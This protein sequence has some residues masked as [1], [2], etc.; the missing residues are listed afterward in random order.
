M[1][2]TIYDLLDRFGAEEVSSWMRGD[3]SILGRLEEGDVEEVAGWDFWSRPGQR[4]EP[5]PETITY[6]SAGRGFGKSLV[7]AHALGEA[8]LDPERWGGEALL[9]GITPGDARALC[10][11]DTGIIRVAAEWGYPQPA[12]KW[13]MGRGELFF[14]HPR[15][16]GSGLHVR[17]A[18]SANPASARGPNVGLLLADEWAFFRQT[19]DEMGL[20]TWEAAM[21]ALRIGLAKA[22]IVSSPSRSKSVLE[23]RDLAERPKCK[24]CGERLPRSPRVKISPLFSADTTQP[25]RTCECGATVTAQVRM[26]RAS[27]LDNRAHLQGQY[28]ERVEA[29]LSSGSR[30]ALG[31]YGGEAL[32][33]D[34]A[35]PIA[36]FT[37]RETF[38]ADV[39]DKW[40]ALR[41]L[42]GI[43][44]VI[45]AVDPATTAGTNSATTGV[46]AAG[47]H[48][49]PP[50]SPPRAVACLEDASVPPEE[51]EGSPS[52]VWAP[53][54]AL[55]AALWRAEEIVVE[56]NQGGLEVLYP[57]R[58]A[59]R[60]LTAADLA[61]HTTDPQVAAACLRAAQAC[62]VEGITRR[63]S[64]AARWDWAS[65]PAAVGDLYALRAPWLSA[66]HWRTTVEHITGF[67][68][69]PTAKRS[70]ESIDRGDTV[71]SAAQR[72]LGA[73]E[74]DSV[75]VVDPSRSPFYQSG[76]L[77]G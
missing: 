49:P 74:V 29:A 62:K 6:Y 38:P 4:W 59:L 13:S 14:P 40:T 39:P 17:V 31:E 58:Q 23:M 61:P 75:R 50:G 21:N 1:L 3:P 32:D 12:T 8:A 10:E 33:D 34:N 15:G 44:R 60:S 63:S 72:L 16:G 42:A 41:E 69:D 54:A 20:T 43:S 2:P 22:V 9:L 46:I 53:R 27:T 19:R 71:I 47:L 68:P 73:R 76:G 45:V 30:Q 66:D 11:Q 5:G 67:T 26:I 25:V 36:R 18:S 51:V 52:R 56:T 24:A 64:K 65:T 7:L 70:Q 35:A 37:V 55:L 57:V 28:V 48:A 77:F